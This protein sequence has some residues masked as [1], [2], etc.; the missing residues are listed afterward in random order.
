MGVEVPG[1]KGRGLQ[2]WGNPVASPHR[3]FD[4]SGG[5]RGKGEMVCS[6]GETKQRVLTEALMGV[7]VPGGKGKWSAVVGEEK[8]RV[9]MKSSW[10]WRYQGKKGK[11]LASPHRG[12]HGSGGT[13]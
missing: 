7:E 5:T 4:G 8:W 10:E 13:R 11:G 6:C 3:G 9:L 2:L 12:F 1:G